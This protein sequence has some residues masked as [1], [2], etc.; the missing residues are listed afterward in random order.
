MK[1]SQNTRILKYL[2]SGK[3]LTGMEALKMFDCFSLSQRIRNLKD[4]GFD[5][6]KDMETTTSGKHIARYKMK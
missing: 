5:I 1:P 4:K 6:D 2:Q 3:T